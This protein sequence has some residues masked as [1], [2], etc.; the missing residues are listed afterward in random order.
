MA[1]KAD[2]KAMNNVSREWR[3]KLINVMAVRV[4]QNILQTAE[5]IK[6][7]IW[8]MRKLQNRGLNK[9]KGRK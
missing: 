7:I 2:N 9:R 1:Q 4:K 3:N 5:A 6:T 8:I